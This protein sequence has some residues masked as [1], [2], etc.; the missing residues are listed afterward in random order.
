MTTTGGRP[1]PA[2]YEIDDR[3]GNP[4]PTD[5][6]RTVGRVRV[7]MMMRDGMTVALDDW[8]RRDHLRP[9]PSA[10]TTARRCIARGRASRTDA[11]ALDA[12]ASK[13]IVEM[14]RGH[15]F[16]DGAEAARRLAPRGQQP[17]DACT[18][19]GAPGHLNHR[20]ECVPDRQDRERA[21]RTTPPRPSASRMQAYA[22]MVARHGLSHGAEGRRADLTTAWSRRR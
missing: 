9:S 1:W 10:S 22:E 11:A 19:N 14:V 2:D 12:Q 18:I 6:L 7:P 4:V 8:Q 15:G 16:P 20:L 5:C 13:P 3:F 17:G 21:R